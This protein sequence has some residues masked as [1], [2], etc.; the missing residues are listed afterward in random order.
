[1][2]A[3]WNLRLQNHCIF[4]D[5]AESGQVVLQHNARSGLRPYIH[6]LRGPDG[7]TCLTEDSP[8][9]HP[10]QHG[11]QTGFHGVNNCDFWFDPG[12]VVGQSIGSI[13]ASAPRI[14]DPTTPR[15]TIEAL[16]RHADGSYLLV[17]AQTWSLAPAENLLYL[18]LDWTVRAVPNIHIEQQPYGGL[19]IRMP[20]RSER[21]AQVL[22]SS[23]Q[24]DDDC[25]QQ[26]AAW[27][28]LFMPLDHSN[29]GAGIALFDH[30]GNARHPAHWRVDAQRGINP[31]PCI[32]DAIDLAAG[33]AMRHRYRLVLH[34]GPLPPEHIQKHWDEYA[35]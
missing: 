27:V 14:I 30:P 26:A 6:P 32:P 33:E 31:A 16:W 21:G 10:W 1:M 22:N 19:F 8:G 3:T 24:R 34:D 28:D 35:G 20:F 4:I 12:Q 15:W 9:H 17:E 5:H 23:G 13:E 2:T 18:D 11:V 29:T 7:R 25:E